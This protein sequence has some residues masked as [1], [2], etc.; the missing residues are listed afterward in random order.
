MLEL[1]TLQTILA[2]LALFA[3]EMVP[4]VPTPHR[5]RPRSP[6]PDGGSHM[7]APANDVELD[8][9]RLAA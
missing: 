3:Q 9:R 6:A 4:Y 8:G 5:F 7:P 2:M 1:L